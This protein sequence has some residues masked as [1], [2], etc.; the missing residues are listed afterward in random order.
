MA[1]Q[2]VAGLLG[3]LATLATVGSAA[4]A[5]GCVDTDPAVFVEASIETPSATLAAGTL[6]TTIAGSF[7]L[8]LHLGARA[9]GPAD[10]DL[11]QV[12]VTTSDGATTLVAPLA[13]ATDSTFP[14]SVEPESDRLVA[15]TFAAE[16]NQLEAAA[17]DAICAAGPI[18]L[19][20]ALDDSLRGGTLRVTSAAFSPAGCP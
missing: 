1:R 20:A 9:S 16:D 19:T 8:R 18:V 10:I 11:G 12:S 3:T 4:G 13:V 6:V 14:V 15:F 7:A 2:L 5:L 17:Y